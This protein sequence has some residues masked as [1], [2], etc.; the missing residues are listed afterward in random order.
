MSRPITMPARGLRALALAAMLAATGCAV[1]PKDFNRAPAMSPVGS[2]VVPGQVPAVLATVPA[3]APPQPGSLWSP[4][5]RGLFGDQRARH[6]GDMLTILVSLDDE[7]EF[8]NESDRSRD[9]GI[10]FG[11][12]I[13]IPE[14]GFSTGVVEGE[15]G[16]SSD[17]VGRGSTERSE[18]LETSIPAVVT[19]VL[20]NGN[21]VISGTQETRVNFEKRVISIAGIVRPFD[22]SRRNT[23]P[24]EKVAEARLTYGG[25]GRLSEVQQPPWGQQLYDNI[26]PF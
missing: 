11:L 5:T 20:P 18:E 10:G 9:S 15:V 25:R 23:V 1:N 26:T 4:T 13:N 17:S 22:I 21:L 7:A 16:T 19:A 14:I 3:M 24:Y 12:G 8:D 6:V 2:G